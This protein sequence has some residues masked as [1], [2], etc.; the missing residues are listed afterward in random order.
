MNNIFNN[1][2]S[3]IGSESTTSI[4]VIQDNLPYFYDNSSLLFDST[5]SFSIYSEELTSSLLYFINIFLTI[6][7]IFEY[8]L[9]T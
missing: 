3:S 4:A 2:D 6:I 5:T 1:S 8:L 7:L 9:L